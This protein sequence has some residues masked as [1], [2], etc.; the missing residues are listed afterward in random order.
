M[1]KIN[2]FFITSERFF[3]VQIHTFRKSV[4]EFFVHNIFVANDENE[5]LRMKS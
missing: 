1:T 4:H 2:C 5:K 3:L